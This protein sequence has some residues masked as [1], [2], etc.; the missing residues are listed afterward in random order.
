MTPKIC[1]VT[2]ASSGLGKE[3]ALGL[4]KQEAHVIMVCRNAEKGQ[5]ALD[6]IK[7]QTQA[8]VELFIVDLSSQADIRAFAKQMHERYSHLDVLINNAG[9][10]LMQQQF[11]VDGIEMTLATNYLAPFLLTNLLLDLLK[12]SKEHVPRII[13][14]SSRIEKWGTLDF[15]D[16]EFKQHPYRFIKAYAQSKLL[17]NIMTFELA[18][19]LPPGISV[20]CLHP[21]AVRSHLGSTNSTN[22]FLRILEKTIKFFCMSPKNA[23]VFPV[24]L[25]LSP[26]T[27]GMTG[28]YFMKGKPANPNPLCHDPILA[29]KVWE[30]SEKWVGL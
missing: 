24:E 5:A 29:K 18:R 13:N 16:P 30:L 8:E 19:R 25:A 22:F 15:N 4:A 1:L 12:G 27:E 2:G 11:S 6:E 7:R 9:V 10:L 21:G 23:A 17:L 20:N 3:I 26:K 28:H 14:I